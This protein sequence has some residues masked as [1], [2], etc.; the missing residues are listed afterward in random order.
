MNIGILTLPLHTNYGGILQAYALQTVL[1]RMGHEV[2]VLNQNQDPIH[3]P[4]T[5]ICLSFIKRIVWAILRRK[6]SKYFNI[7]KEEIEIKKSYSIINENTYTFINRYI[8]QYLYRSL[9]NDVKRDSFDLLIVGSDQVWRPAYTRN[10]EDMFFGF[11]ATWDVPK[12][13]YAASFGTDSWEY[14]VTQ[15]DN[16]SKLIKKFKAVSV[17]EESGVKLCREHL[18]ISASHVLDP[19]ML[20]DK[21]DYSRLFSVNNA[22]SIN[23]TL[24]TYVLDYDDN[25]V[26]A[27]EKLSKELELKVLRLNSKVEDA[28]ATI[29][30]RIQPPVESWLAGLCYADFVITDSFHACVF[31]IIFHKPFYVLANSYRGVSRI[32]SLLKIFGLEN[33]MIT[34]VGECNVK[35]RIDWKKIDKIRANWKSHSLTFLTKNIV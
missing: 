2:A 29:E 4:A 6:M 5:K 30:E 10:I 26:S 13:A 19:T 25:K 24:A 31:C 9:S 18:G 28:T 23:K 16:C 22:D 35:E 27:I 17:R 11:A 21:D 32:A 34:D 15:T 8:H 20:L 12:L 3:Y 1:E 33:R 14:S 7:Q